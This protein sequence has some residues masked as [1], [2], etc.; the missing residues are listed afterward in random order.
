[1]A[2][3]QVADIQFNKGKKREALEFRNYTPSFLNLSMTIIDLDGVISMGL[4]SSKTSQL[5]FLTDG[6]VGSSVNN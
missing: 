1:M 6:C 4:F 3:S 5:R 2:P